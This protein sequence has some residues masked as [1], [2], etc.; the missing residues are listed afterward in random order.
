MERSGCKRISLSVLFYPNAT[1]M[2]DVR[3]TVVLFSYLYSHE[4]E[5]MSISIPI[6]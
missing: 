2:Y 1:L 4:K 6:L 5:E 3:F